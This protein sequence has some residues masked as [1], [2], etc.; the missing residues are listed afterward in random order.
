MTPDDLSLNSD[1]LVYLYVKDHAYDHHCVE[2]DENC[3]LIF[4]CSDIRK[5][6]ISLQ[7]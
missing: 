6:I 3:K 2:S 7:I 5:H 4:N 1:F